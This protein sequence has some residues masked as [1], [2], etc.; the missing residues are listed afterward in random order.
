MNLTDG[1]GGKG[2]KMVV[3]CSLMDKVSVRG[4]ILTIADSSQG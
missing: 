2:T 1:K 4:G 3:E